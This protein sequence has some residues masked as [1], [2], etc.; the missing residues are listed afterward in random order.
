[1][2]SSEM[3]RLASAIN[4]PRQ[5]SIVVESLET[6]HREPNELKPLSDLPR[7]SQNT[8]CSPG[9][10]LPNMQA[11]RWRPPPLCSAQGSPSVLRPSIRQLAQPHG[12]E[13]LAQPRPTTTCRR[14]AT[15]RPPPNG[16]QHLPRRVQAYAEPFQPEKPY[17]KGAQL[18]C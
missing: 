12:A 7:C 14:P 2:A 9:A 6:Q 10:Q 11:L 5:V 18:C 1:M 3:L 16:G 8:L 4:D 17:H 15:R 13:T